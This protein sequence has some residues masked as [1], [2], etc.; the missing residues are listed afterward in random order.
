MPPGDIGDDDAVDQALGDDLELLLRRPI[1]ATLDAGDHLDPLQ[2]SRLGV[3]IMVDSMVKTIARH[4]AQR[5][6]IRYCDGRCGRRTA[7]DC[8]P[9]AM[10][11]DCKRCA[12]PTYAGVI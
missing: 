7:Y 9:A 8:I 5:S 3:V 12:S 11:L 1:A 6:V 2:P 4:A 10:A